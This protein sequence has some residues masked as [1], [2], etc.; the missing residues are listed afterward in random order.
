MCL[1]NVLKLCTEEIFLIRGED[2]SNS[3]NASFQLEIYDP[4]EQSQDK[5]KP[6]EA[7]VTDFEQKVSVAREFVWGWTSSVKVNGTVWNFTR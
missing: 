2:Y 5:T 1:R 6:N 4:I 3:L 7:E